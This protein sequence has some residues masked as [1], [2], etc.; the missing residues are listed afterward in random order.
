VY[1]HSTPP[2]SQYDEDGYLPQACSITAERVTDFPFGEELP[3]ELR[4]RLEQLVRETGD[5]GDVIT[6][7]A[8]WKLGGWPTWHV[9]RWGD[10][11]ARPV[12]TRCSA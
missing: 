4:P 8:G 12:W 11:S 6:R 1:D 3:A 2:P 5:G 10:L 7:L 9:G